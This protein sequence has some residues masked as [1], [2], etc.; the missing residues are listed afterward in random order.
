MQIFKFIA[1]THS[2]QMKTYFTTK[3]SR[4]KTLL[5]WRKKVVQKHD[6]GR[7]LKKS[8]SHQTSRRNLLCKNMLLVLLASWQQFLLIQPTCSCS[9]TPEQRLEEPFLLNVGYS[10]SFQTTA[11]VYLTKGGCHWCALGTVRHKVQRRSWSKD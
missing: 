10:H 4:K 7:Q 8:G 3:S 6:I 2:A 5:L 9:T 1:V 11:L